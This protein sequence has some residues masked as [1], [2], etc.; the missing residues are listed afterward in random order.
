VRDPDPQILGDSAGVLVWGGTCGELA[1]ALELLSAFLAGRQPPGGTGAPPRLSGRLV[2]V[3]QMCAT[4]AREQQV[5]RHRELA[6]LAQPQPL[7]A[8]V[9]PSPA[10]VSGSSNPATITTQQAAE[11]LGVTGQRV[12]ELCSAGRLTA[13]CGPRR[14]WEI[15]PG[16]VAAYAARQA[17]RRRTYEAARGDAEPRGAAQ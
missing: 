5:A 13:T 7:A 11:R 1:G 8:P 16:S 9:L 3:Q 12:R 17:K 10:Q 2:A 6:K 4:V 15:D 14:T